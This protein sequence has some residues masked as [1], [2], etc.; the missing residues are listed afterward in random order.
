MVIADDS[1]RLLH[2]RQTTRNLHVLGVGQKMEVTVPVKFIAV[3]LDQRD[4]GGA[5]ILPNPAVAQDE[6]ER[7][8]GRK[9]PGLARR[10]LKD[11]ILQPGDSLF[12]RTPLTR[13]A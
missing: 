12:Q 4:E 10:V 13:I 3:C 5:E 7:S 9:N 8:M 11:G 6:G 2:R 1:D